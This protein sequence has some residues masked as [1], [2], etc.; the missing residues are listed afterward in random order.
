[1]PGPVARADAKEALTQAACGTDLGSAKAAAPTAAWSAGL[2]DAQIEGRLVTKIAGSL[3]RME[4]LEHKAR[5]LARLRHY[6]AYTYGPCAD[7]RAFVA[8][9]PAPTA[10]ARGKDG[11]V[12][13]PAA[14]LAQ[15]CTSYRVDFAPRE[16]GEV[17][18]LRA[19]GGKFAARQIKSLGDGVASVTCQPRAPRWQGPMLWYLFP[20]GQGPLEAP[21]QPDALAG[22]SVAD[23]LTSWV[24]RVRVENG[25]GA[26]E[27]SAA[28]ANDAELLLTA[29]G[30]THDRSLIAKVQA[31]ATERRER[32]LGEDRVQGQDARAMAWLLWNSPRHR[33]LVVDPDATVCGVAVREGEVE[34]LA[35]LACAAKTPLTTARG[36][37]KPGRIQR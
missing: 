7:G 10:L 21:P 6:G 29:P 14:A 11:S 34:S 4:R 23:A 36:A 37:K 26:V 2:F 15:R 32:F 13:L 30:L 19:V 17:R 3:V 27:R 22:P 25:R 9:L 20:V 31:A 24:N 18:E 8:A 16:K 33:S 28:L 5:A 1:M 35:V 12:T